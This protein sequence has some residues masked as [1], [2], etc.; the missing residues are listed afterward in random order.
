MKN[1]N[2]YQV[3]HA[4]INLQW[5]APVAEFV[6]LRLLSSGVA[7]AIVYAGYLMFLH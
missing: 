4:S 7:T 3:K 2:T 1:M 5:F 6:A